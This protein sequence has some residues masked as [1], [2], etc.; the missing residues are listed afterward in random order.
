MAIDVNTFLHE[1]TVADGAWGTTLA[2]RW[3]TGD[4]RPE[5]WNTAHPDRIQSLACEYV[6]AGAQILMTNTFGAN[7]FV[8]DREGLG[9]CVEEINR[10]G[11]R[12]LKEVVDADVLIFGSMGPTGKIVMLGE[13]EPNSLREAFT[14]QAVALTEAG[15]DAIVIESMTELEEITVAI[16]AVKSATE[17]PVVASM[18]FDAGSD[19]TSTTMGVTAP[20]AANAL[21]GAGADVIGCNC[22]AGIESAVFVVHMLRAETDLPIWAKPGA[23]IP[24]VI[25]GRAAYT[26]TPDEFA[27]YVPA[28]IGSGANIVGG[29]CGTDPGF[30]RAVR[31]MVEKVKKSLPW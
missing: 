4:S 7:R 28:L 9:D 29:C 15:A 12:I 14:E 31:R 10:A 13:I 17:V 5:Q 16:S 26:Q 27:G 24:E 11:V 2:Q 23:G 18:S 8:L 3:P 20:D 30:I 1:L 25:E 19:S 22:G 21:V 6:G